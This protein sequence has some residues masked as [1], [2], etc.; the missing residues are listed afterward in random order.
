MSDFMKW[1]LTVVFVVLASVSF[2]W[3]NDAL[4]EMLEAR[5]EYTVC[6]VEYTDEWLE[7]REDCADQEEVPVFDSSEYMDA[8]YDDLEDLEEATEEA[9]RFEFGVAMWQLGLDSLDLLVAIIADALTDKNL[10]FFSCVR[11]GEEPLMEDRDDCRLDAMEL[12]REAAKDYVNN[13]IDYANDQIEDMD[14][15][16]ADTS[17]MEEVV[18]YGE[19]LVDDI[20]PAFDTGEISEIRKLHLRHSR[21]VLLFRLEKMLATIDYVEPIIEDGDNDNKEEI[22]ERGDELRDEVEEVLD[23]CEYS[24]EV[25]DNFDYGRDNLECWDDSIDLFDEFIAIG[26][27]ILE[28]A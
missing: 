16:G 7:M 12:E 1:L 27:L 5:Y 6:N 13:E 2:A 28:G 4:P 18:E 14:E 22:L 8:L 21:L 11:D 20:D 15:L 26:V 19:E 24:D 10:D 9:D 17:G 23:Q 3:T 25:D